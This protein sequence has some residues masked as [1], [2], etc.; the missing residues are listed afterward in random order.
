MERHISELPGRAVVVTEAGRNRLEQ[1]PDCSVLLPMDLREWFA[2]EL[3]A[4]WIEEGIEKLQAQEPLETAEIGTMDAFGRTMLSLLSFSY[5]IGILD[6]R[7][8]A[9]DA[10]T[11][12]VLRLLSC[13]LFP[14]HQ[15]L[16]R[17]RRRHRAL[18]IALLFELFVRAISQKMGRHRMAG[19]PDLHGQLLEA[20]IQ[21]L[22]IAIQLDHVD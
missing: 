13:N 8:I 2:P 7:G 16:R 10:R 12:T 19:G 6:S 22:D 20:A 15:E 4:T 9:Y 18:L 3:L 5:A 1:R 21:R 14:F 11:N 17:F